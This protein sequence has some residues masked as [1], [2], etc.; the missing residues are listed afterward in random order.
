[1]KSIRQIPQRL[2]G[3]IFC[4]VAACLSCQLSAVRAEDWKFD[5]KFAEAVHNQPFTGRVYLLFSKLNA[6]P[7]QG[8]SWFHPEFFVARDVTDWRA[9]ESLA[10]SS[11]EP[12]EMFAYPQPLA[13]MPLAGYRAQAVVRFNPW[14]RE[15]GVGSGNGF[16]S[17]VELPEKAPADPIAFKVSKLVPNVIFHESK[18]CKLLAVKSK[19]LSEFYKRDVTVNAAVLLPASYERE[20]DRRYPVMF[21]IPGFG[22]T[23]YDFQRNEPIDEKNKNDVEFI[24]VTL[25]PSCPLGHHVFADSE[26]NGPWGT[27]LVEEFIPEFDRQYRSVA[28]PSARFLTGHS[29]GGWS[30]LWLQV[31]YPD[32]FGGVWST[33]PDPVDFHDF[34]RINLYR[35]G[36][37]MYV[38][39][40]GD[41]R[42]LAR[43]GERVLLWYRGFAD[44]E[45][46][47][48]PGGQLHSFEAVFSHRGDDGQP[49]LLWNR[50]T[51]EIDL[52]VAKSWERY[53]IRLILERNWQTLEPQLKGKL[54]VFMGD[55]DTFYLEGATK[56]LK[57]SLSQLK[58]DAV[59][60]LIPGRTHFDLLTPDL[61]K[62]I[63][64]EMVEK[65]LESEY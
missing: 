55:T 56:L 22:G 8:P 26:N 52:D 3:I 19:V 49:K 20:P 33:A 41:R 5:V 38:D 23:H 64:G 10:F 57:E 11:A 40:K 62:R 42:P 58:S 65:F 48:G 59:V 4:F 36:E 51:G 6:E 21:T 44:M 50:E 9:G 18:W 60:E 63:R 34:Q 7:R 54:H 24:R 16:S 45:W 31:T 37:N 15:I 12:D 43:D 53:D 28:K 39:E 17:T 14:E 30:S 32:H 29:S 27:A 61:V 2:S 35:S 13:E 47:L 46:V 1:M 25:D